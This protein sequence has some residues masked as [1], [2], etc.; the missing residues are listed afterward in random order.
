[1]QELVVEQEVREKI[2]M[3]QIVVI[4]LNLNMILGVA[5]KNPYLLTRVTVMVTTTILNAWM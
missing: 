4:I 5:M 1:M 2:H 3:I